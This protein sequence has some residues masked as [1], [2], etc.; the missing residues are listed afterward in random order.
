MFA[1]SVVV[2]SIADLVKKKSH[3]EDRKSLLPSIKSL[4]PMSI[5]N[6]RKNSKFK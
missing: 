6:F 1:S 3:G 5:E 4:D 2:F